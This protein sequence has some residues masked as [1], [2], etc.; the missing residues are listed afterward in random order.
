MACQDRF[1]FSFKGDLVALIV[2]E[3]LEPFKPEPDSRCHCLE[4]FWSLGS[5]ATICSL[6]RT[7]IFQTVF[8]SPLSYL[9]TNFSVFH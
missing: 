3:L 5:T 2:S 1:S 6:S 7:P 8:G 4:N 9:L